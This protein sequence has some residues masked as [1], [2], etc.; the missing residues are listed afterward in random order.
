MESFYLGIQEPAWMRKLGRPVFL[1][2]K[3]LMYKDGRII[4]EPEINCPWA[5]DSGG[6]TEIAKH[7]RWTITA[8]EYVK[9]VGQ[10]IPFGVRW[11]AIMDWMCEAPMLKK[12]GKTVKEH[13]TLTVDNYLDLMHMAPDYP[14]V[15]VLQ[16]M[17]AEDYKRH[18]DQ[19]ASAGFDLSS[20]PLVGL[21]SV[22]RRQ[23]FTEIHGLARWL[24]HDQGLR[25]HGFGVSLR[26]LRGLAPNL[27]SSDSMAWSYEARMLSAPI[28]PI[29][30][31]NHCGACFR[32]AVAWRFKV[33]RKLARLGFPGVE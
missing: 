6:F 5:L 19:Y 11:A 25:L 29:C 24:K 28:F 2:R 21:G 32:A 26:G 30:T 33:L 16:G 27:V 13:Q 17:E 22:C 20:L 4:R 18:L 9:F 10:M 14:W 12:T 3:R 8:K 31:H 23:N 1:S 7:G 15:P